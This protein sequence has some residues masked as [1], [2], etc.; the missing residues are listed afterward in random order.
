MYNTYV[1]IG[2]ILL[3]KGDSLCSIIVGF[4]IFIGLNKIFIGFLGIFLLE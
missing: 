3:L 2:N 4:I 1:Y